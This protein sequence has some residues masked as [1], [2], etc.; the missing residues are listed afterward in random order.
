MP[1]G[2]VDVAVD[3]EDLQPSHQEY[4]ATRFVDAVARRE[5]QLLCPW[6]IRCGWLARFLLPAALVDLLGLPLGVTHMMD[7]FVGHAK[8]A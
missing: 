7:N 2:P 6:F 3:W 1:R 5:Q 4:A 8:A